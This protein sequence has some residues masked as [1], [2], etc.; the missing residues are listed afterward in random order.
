MFRMI[1]VIVICNSIG[2]RVDSCASDSYPVLELYWPYLSV[3][4][5]YFLVHL[6]LAL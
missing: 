3:Y 2:N 5:R 4:F 1:Q 6:V